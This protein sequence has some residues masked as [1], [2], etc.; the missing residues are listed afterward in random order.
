MRAPISLPLGP[1]EE[2]PQAYANLAII[3]PRPMKAAG[4]GK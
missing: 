2:Y 4:I 1:P 3:T